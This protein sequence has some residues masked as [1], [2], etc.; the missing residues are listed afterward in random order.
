MRRSDTRD[1][2]IATANELIWRNSYNAVSVDEICKQSGVRKGSFYHYFESKSKLAIATILS[3]CE[4]MKERNDDMFSPMRP[5]LERFELMVNHIITHQKEISE[6]YGHV[7]GCP[8]I[9]L[10]S[11]MAMQDEEMAKTI[12]DIF[13]KKTAYYKNALL[14]LHNQGKIPADTDIDVKSKE[15]F[16]FIVGH[17]T[18]ARIRND[19]EFL[20]NS[21]KRSLFQL[22]GIKEE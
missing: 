14:E 15:I 2:L 4:Q 21:L 12:S 17:L 9:S 8:F 11:E 1:K 10:G 13:D 5:P 20:E 16:S 6:K 18:V 3:C 19:I 7:C 22:I